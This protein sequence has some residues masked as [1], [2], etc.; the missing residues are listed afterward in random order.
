MNSEPQNR[1]RFSRIEFDAE[2]TLCA[3]DRRIPV[4]LVDISLKG[5]LV[6]LAEPEADI[7][8]ELDLNVRL[9]G[10]EQEIHMRC[11]IAHTD[12]TLLGLQCVSIELDSASHLRRLVE[13]NLGDPDL[14]DRELANLA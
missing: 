7:P 6:R 3:A 12:G 11:Q 13:L 9:A 2:S 10:H 8:N 1:R 4:T 14:L 5:A